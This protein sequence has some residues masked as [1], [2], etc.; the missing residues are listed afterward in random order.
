VRE[1]MLHAILLWEFYDPG[2]GVLTKVAVLKNEEVSRPNLK[3]PI[4]RGDPR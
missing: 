3:G 2:R 4:L 1:M